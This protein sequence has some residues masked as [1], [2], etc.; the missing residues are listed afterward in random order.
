M[1]PSGFIIRILAMSRRRRVVL[2]LSVS[3]EGCLILGSNFNYMTRAPKT[4]NLIMFPCMKG[5][6]TPQR[7]RMHLGTEQLLHEH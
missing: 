4:K 3:W 6:I 5:F 2:P 7:E 1:S